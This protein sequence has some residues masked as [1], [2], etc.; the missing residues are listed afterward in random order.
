MK[1][2]IGQVVKIG[3]KIYIPTSGKVY[4]IKSFTKGKFGKDAIEVIDGLRPWTGKFIK[5]FKQK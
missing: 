3:D 1:D 2:S 5:I 4:K